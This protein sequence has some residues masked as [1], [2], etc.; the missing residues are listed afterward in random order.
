VWSVSR[1]SLTGRSHLV[2]LNLWMC[3][4]KPSRLSPWILLGLPQLGST[5]C[6]MVVVDKYTKYNHFISLRHPYT[7]ISVAKAFLDQV[8][9]LH[10][11]PSSIIYDRDRV[12]TSKFWKE[13]FHQAMVQWSMSSVYHPQSNGQ[14][15]CMNQ[16]METF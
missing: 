3:L 11:M 2:C 13:L 6:I 12:F 8:Y 7:A 14:S 15:E 5:N 1:L 4:M 10:E 16:C 9:R